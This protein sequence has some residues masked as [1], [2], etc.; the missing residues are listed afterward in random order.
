MVPVQST[1][2]LYHFWSVL[3]RFMAS[4]WDVYHMPKSSTQRVNVFCHETCFHSPGMHV[5]SMYPCGVSRFL[6]SLL[7]RMP[8]CGRPYMPLTTCKYKYP[9]VMSGA[10]LYSSM[11]CW[12]MYFMAMQAY[13]RWSRGV[14]R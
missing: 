11:N 9:L 1:V 6:R 8:A 5:H 10:R 3:M 13:S 2:I 14:S 12:G 4:I 7:A